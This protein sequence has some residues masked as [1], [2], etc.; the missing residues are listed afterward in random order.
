MNK[1]NKIKDS[2]EIMKNLMTLIGKMWM[3][4]RR[5]SLPLLDIL[6]FLI[7]KPVSVRLIRL[8]LRR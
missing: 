4:M 5:K 1:R 7:V 2:Q 8:C 3:S 6:T